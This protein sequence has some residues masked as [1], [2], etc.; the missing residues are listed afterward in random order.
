M[1]TPGAA[2]GS[3]LYATDLLTNINRA[4]VFVVRMKSNSYPRG[5]DEFK[6]EVRNTQQR[7]AQT[8]G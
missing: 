2:A 1:A 3:S 6:I 4:A 5:R 8:R 7:G